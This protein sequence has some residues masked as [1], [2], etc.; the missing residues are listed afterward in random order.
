VSAPG[1]AYGSRDVL[2]VDTECADSIY[3]YGSRHGSQ[4]D[5]KLPAPEDNT[6]DKGTALNH[7]DAD[8]FMINVLT[9]LEQHICN[10]HVVRRHWNPAFSITNDDWIRLDQSSDIIVF[11]D[12]YVFSLL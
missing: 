10:M 12:N 11:P 7:K 9:E 2:Q 3:Q 8:C 5:R 4:G 1:T 6:D